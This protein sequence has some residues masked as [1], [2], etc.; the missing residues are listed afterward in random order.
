MNKYSPRPLHR[1]DPLHFANAHYPL[2]SA[3]CL[4][5]T[6]YGHVTKC[7]HAPNHPDRTDVGTGGVSAMAVA[8]GNVSCQDLQC[9][10][11]KMTADTGAWGRTLKQIAVKAQ[12]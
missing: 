11:E 12:C 2:P 10:G 3:N 7:N 1:H 8:L 4:L 9:K 5:T 6:A